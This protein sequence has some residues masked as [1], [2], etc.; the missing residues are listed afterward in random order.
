M[1][2]LKIL[3]QLGSRERVFFEGPTP[4]GES[5]DFPILHSFSLRHSFRQFRD[6]LS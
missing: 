4:Q 1:E 6:V 2:V 5:E 3:L